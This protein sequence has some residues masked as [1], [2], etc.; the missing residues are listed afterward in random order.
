MKSFKKILFI[1][2]CISACLSLFLI[3]D[4]Y[5]RY[6][7]SATGTAD[8]AIARWNITVNDLTIK[9]NTDLSSKITPT[10]LG[11]DHIA[12]NIIAPTAEGFFDL[13]I[14]YEN[15][16]VSFDYEISVTSNE[17]TPVTDLIVTGYSIDGG[18]IIQLED[19]L[20]ISGTV[21]NTETIKE[22]SIRVYI[23]WDDENG[24]M[25]NAADTATTIPDNAKALLDVNISF[26]QKA[27]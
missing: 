1:I 4:T 16:D 15:A 8:I 13:N 5:S 26:T 21:L 18:E 11:T 23:M 22:K 17:N 27:S 7:T 12:A 9:N 20:N 3:A 6:V 14:N 19:S 25:D 2:S 24:T 10:F